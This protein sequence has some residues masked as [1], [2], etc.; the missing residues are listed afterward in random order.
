[1]L[2]I[3]YDPHV[4]HQPS[5]AGNKRSEARLQCGGKEVQIGAVDIGIQYVLRHEGP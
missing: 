3:Y 1:M 2:L 4:A 5:F